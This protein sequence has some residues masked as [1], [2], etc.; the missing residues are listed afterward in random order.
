MF[1]GLVEEIGNVVGLDRQGSLARLRITARLTSRGT[2]IGDSICVNGCCLTVVT[3]DRSE[4][5]ENGVLG[6]EMVPETLERTNLGQLQAGTPV[7]L[8]RSLRTDSRLGGHFVTGH[9]DGI[10]RIERIESDGETRVMWFSAATELMTQMA[11]KGSVAI[12]GISLTL[13]AVDEQQFSVALIPHT[14][15]ET[16]IGQRK[17]GDAVNIETDLLA[18]YVQRQLDL[19]SDFDHPV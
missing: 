11:G 10:A 13:V 2:V 3:V 12:D 16:V 6:F 4:D 18:K 15:Q 8:E 7:N 9:I 14:L 17:A 19:R 5:G 1:T